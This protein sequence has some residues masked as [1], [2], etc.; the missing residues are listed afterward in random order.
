MSCV[1]RFERFVSTLVSPFLCPR[2]ENSFPVVLSGQQAT[3]YAVFENSQF[4]LSVITL[5][6]YEKLTLVYAEI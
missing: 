6:T 1:L 5:H 2:P 4:Y 3:P